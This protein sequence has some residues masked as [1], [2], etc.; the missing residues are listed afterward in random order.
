MMKAIY[1]SKGQKVL[2]D[3]EDFGWLNESKWYLTK[4]GYATNNI[5]KLMH[6]LIMKSSSKEITDHMNR[7]KLDNRKSNLRI[8]TTSINCFNSKQR[9][10]NNSGHKGVVWKKSIGKWVAQIGF[11]S[12]TYH[13][14]CFHDIQGALLA[15][16]WGERTYFG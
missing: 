12:K 13:L 3:D 5:G 16:R 14:G 1:L 4:K 6:K 10:N 8:T 11:T 9:I 15:R 2:V 7:N